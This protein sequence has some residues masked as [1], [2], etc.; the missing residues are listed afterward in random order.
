MRP[1]E[2]LPMAAQVIFSL[3]DKGGAHLSGLS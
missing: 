1:R 2:V 3:G